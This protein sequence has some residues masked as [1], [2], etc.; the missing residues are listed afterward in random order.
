LDEPEFV[1]LVENAGGEAYV[2]GGWVRDTL[3]G[4]VPRDKDYVV[5]GLTPEDFLSVFP[6][7]VRLGGGF[8]VYG[9]RIGG[10]MCDVAFAR[11]DV[12]NGRG[13]K[14]FSVSSDRETPIEDD[15]FRRDTT[16]N[17]MALRLRTGAI[18]DP[19]GGLYDI[20][21]RVIRAVSECFTEDPVRALR[22]ARQAAE[23][24][25]RIEPDTVRLMGMCRD[26]LAC[27][28]RER[29]VREMALALSAA[30]PSVFFKSL[31]E[32]GLL[33][34]TYPQ[35]HALSGAEPYDPC[36]DF[37]RS[38]ESLDAASS[39][40][41]RAEV[42]FAA[43]CALLGGIPSGPA[44]AGREVSRV[45]ALD[46]WKRSMPLPKRWTE[47]AEFVIKEMAHVREDADPRETAGLLVRMRRHPIGPDGFAAVMKSW[48]RTADYIEDPERYYR[49]MGEITGGS[50]PS[51][52]SG[53]ARG[54]WMA[55]RRAEAVSACRSM[56][57][58]NGP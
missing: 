16:I 31:L 53:P 46:A 40:T 32:A 29:I 8:P 41:C 20:E 55:E 57:K 37:G 38:M 3:R 24:G 22:A 56:L 26:E 45:P 1:L 12:K 47:C 28:P 27:E 14:G 5:T 35:V 17:S 50:I 13:Y 18:I 9:L 11:R 23:F 54:E 52:L 36:G 58:K 51:R 30:R 6:G 49:A 43:L 15:L 34:V 39:M 19:F 10:A 44:G 25:F 7:A 48:G 42:R 21:R 2:V 33:G 4:E